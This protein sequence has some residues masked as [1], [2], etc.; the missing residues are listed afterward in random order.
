MGGEGG[1]RF[2]EFTVTLTAAVLVAPGF[3]AVKVYVVL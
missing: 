2:L 3:D 1:C